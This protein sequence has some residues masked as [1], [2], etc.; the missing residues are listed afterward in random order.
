MKY[1]DGH[2]GGSPKTVLA[3][4]MVSL[5]QI[6]VEKDMLLKMCHLSGFYFASIQDRTECCFENLVFF[7]LRLDGHSYPDDD[8]DDDDD[9][10]EKEKKKTV[11]LRRLPESNFH[12]EV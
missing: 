10:F 6:F 9:V 5:C 7:C 11:H 8:D 4:L 3:E 2:F 1:R 12:K